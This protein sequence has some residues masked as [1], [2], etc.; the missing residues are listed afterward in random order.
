MRERIEFIQ[1]DVTQN[2]L[3]KMVIDGNITVV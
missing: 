2:N 1:I 3:S